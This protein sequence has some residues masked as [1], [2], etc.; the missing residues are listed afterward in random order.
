MKEDKNVYIVINTHP[1]MCRDKEKSHYME[2]PIKGVF[3][4]WDLAWGFI[5]DNEKDGL[6][7][8]VIET[9][10]GTIKKEEV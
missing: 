7:H 9:V 2:K 4:T 3:E 5:M 1:E 10:Q 8:V 6:W